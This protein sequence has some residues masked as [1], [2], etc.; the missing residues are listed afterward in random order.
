MTTRAPAEQHVIAKPGSRRRIPYV[1]WV[2]ADAATVQK[3][4]NRL[5]ADIPTRDIFSI[6]NRDTTF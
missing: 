5:P 3:I 6:S 1:A 2:P 4:P